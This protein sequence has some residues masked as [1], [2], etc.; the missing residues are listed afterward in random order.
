MLDF[1]KKQTIGTWI[2]LGA[3]IMTLVS[4]I[5]YGVGVGGAGYFSGRG[6]TSLVVCTVLALVFLVAILVLPQ[7][8]FDGI[9][10]FILDILVDMLKILVPLMLGI[11][12]IN[13]IGTRVEGLA[14]IYFSNEDVLSTIQTPENLFSAGNA[15]ITII[16]YFVTIVIACVAAFFGFRKKAKTE[17]SEQKPAGENA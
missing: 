2:S 13:F 8:K 6:V 5:I 3:F 14:Y 10:G 16:M 1:I 4:V 12:V 17:K 15:I 9:L 11:A 7:F